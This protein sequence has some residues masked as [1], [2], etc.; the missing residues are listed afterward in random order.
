LVIYRIVVYL[1]IYF[2][3]LSFARMLHKRQTE[4]MNSNISSANRFIIIYCRSHPS[5]SFGGSGIRRVVHVFGTAK[6][7]I[8]CAKHLAKSP[9]NIFAYSELNIFHLK[10]KKTVLAFTKVATIRPSHRNTQI[11]LH[12]GWPSNDMSRFYL[13]LTNIFCLFLRHLC[14]FRCIKLIRKPLMRSICKI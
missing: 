9:I 3:A 14:I 8:L 4:E 13:K 5:Q 2:F 6:R 1:Y 11:F 12:Y 10:H 7:Y